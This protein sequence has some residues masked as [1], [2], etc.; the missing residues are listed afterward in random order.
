[1]LRLRPSLALAATGSAL[2]RRRSGMVDA[3][4]EIAESLGYDSDA[5]LGFRCS[6]PHDRH[7][8]RSGHLASTE[9]PGLYVFGYQFVSLV[10][11]KP[12][13]PAACRVRRYG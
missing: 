9:Q 3:F 4:M 11:A 7:L 6:L 1:M 13:S 5:I 2:R 8:A 12:M 10:T